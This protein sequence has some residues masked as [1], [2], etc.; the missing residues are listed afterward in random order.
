MGVYRFADVK[1]QI[2]PI[3]DEVPRQCRRGGQ[4]AVSFCCIHA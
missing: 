4:A 2:E 3:H 1:V